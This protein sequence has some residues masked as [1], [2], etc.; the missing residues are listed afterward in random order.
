MELGILL[1]L[2]CAKN[3]T[4]IL[5]FP[6]SSQGRDPY[7]YDFVEKLTVACIQTELFQSW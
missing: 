3:L 1:R 4:L 6:F 7:L 2:A 5:S